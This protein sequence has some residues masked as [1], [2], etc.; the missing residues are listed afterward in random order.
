MK[1]TPT[2]KRAITIEDLLDL[3]WVGEPQVSPTGLHAVYV[4]KEIDAK[5]DTHRSH[6]WL[7]ALDDDSCSPTQL[8]SGEHRDV[9]PRWS[10][11]GRF[12]GG[13]DGVATNVLAR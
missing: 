13:Q 7:V 3:R 6:L 12:I 5:R 8:T 10:A 4:Q 9:L 11:D 2:A 1:R